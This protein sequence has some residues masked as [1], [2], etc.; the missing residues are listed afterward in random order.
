MSGQM[1]NEMVTLLSQVWK[2]VCKIDL[3][4]LDPN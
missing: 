2:E 4:G 1:Q 3:S